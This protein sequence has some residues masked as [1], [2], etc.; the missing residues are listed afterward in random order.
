[1]K[2]VKRKIVVAVTGASGAAYA[3][4]LFK[5]LKELT[6]ILVEQIKNE[7]IKVDANIDLF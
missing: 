3:S 5:Q 1:M 4:V 7:G 2:N 6:N